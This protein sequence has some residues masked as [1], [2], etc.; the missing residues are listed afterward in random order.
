MSAFPD[1]AMKTEQLSVFL[2]NRAGRLGEIINL[3]SE[4]GIDIRGI[5]LADTSDFGILRL[6]VNDIAKTENLLK[7]KGFTTGKTSVVAVELDDKPGSLA[8]ILTELSRENINVEYMYAYARRDV[9]KAI[10]VFRFDRLDEAIDVLMKKNLGII[11][12]ADLLK[13]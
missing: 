6:M 5:S 4:N 3:L 13:I 1:Y 10:M 7:Q 11:S 8:N 2:E 12:E 9:D